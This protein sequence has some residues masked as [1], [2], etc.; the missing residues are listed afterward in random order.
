MQEECYHAEVTYPTIPESSDV[1]NIVLELPEVARIPTRKRTFHINHEDIETLVRPLLSYHWH[2]GRV[3][4]VVDDLQVFSLNKLFN[5]KNFRSS[6]EFFDTL[7]DI[8][9]EEE[10]S[11]IEHDRHVL[12]ALTI[13][14]ASRACHRRLLQ[15]L[16]FRSYTC[17]IPAYL[18]SRHGGEADQSPGSYS[19]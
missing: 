3:G 2:V 10:V 15:C 13:A 4:N 9:D 8:Q 1:Q 14:S 11:S 7:A 16:H 6:V 12:P 18:R 19:P 5:F 17:G